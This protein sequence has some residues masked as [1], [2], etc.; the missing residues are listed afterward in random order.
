[1]PYRSDYTFLGSRISANLK[2]FT[3][4]VKFF[5]LKMFYMSK[6][7]FIFPNIC[8][9]KFPERDPKEFILKF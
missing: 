4:F 5:P 8:V 9:K 1:M 6:I 3:N 2:I 7:T